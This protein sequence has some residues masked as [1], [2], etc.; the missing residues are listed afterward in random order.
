MGS[1][2][3]DGILIVAGNGLHNWCYRHE[4]GNP[5]Y[6]KAMADTAGALEDPMLSHIGDDPTFIPCD[7]DA[8]AL[9][10]GRSRRQSYTTMLYS[11]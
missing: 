5:D 8:V 6:L 10:R 4:G 7:Q 9:Q 1:E 11:R 3:Q 2:A